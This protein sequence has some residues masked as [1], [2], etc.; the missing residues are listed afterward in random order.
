[1]PARDHIRSAALREWV[2]YDLG[3]F[4]E[5]VVR[6]A[7]LTASGLLRVPSERGRTT[8]ARLAMRLRVHAWTQ[9]LCCAPHGRQDRAAGVGIDV[10]QEQVIVGRR[11]R[12]W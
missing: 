11:G 4:R 7:W 9:I 3:P 6:I 12:L 2:T 1:M 5:P 10:L 8:G